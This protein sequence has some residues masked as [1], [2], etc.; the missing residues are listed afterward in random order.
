M[1]DRRTTPGTELGGMFPRDFTRDYVV[2]SKGRGPYVWDTE[3]NRYIDAVSGNKN[4]NIGHGRPEI[5]EAAAEQLERLEFSGMRFANTPSIEFTAKIRELT[6]D[7]Y[8]HAWVV[9][10]G[11]LANESAVK[12]ARQYH[13]ERGNPQKYKI[14][15][16]SKSYHGNTTGAMAWSGSPVYTSSMDPLFVD[17]PK[18][19]SGSQYRCKF[20][21]GDGGR[22]CGI[23]CAEQVDRVIK[24]EGPEN[25]AAFITEPVS[26][27]INAGAYPHDGYFTRVKE[28][29]EKHDVLFIAD[30]V[31]TGFGRTGTVFAME[32]W[33]VMPD[34]VTAG[35]GITAGY[36]PI[37]VTIPHEQVADVFKSLPHGFSHG[38]TYTFSPTT[39]AIG[40]AVL[41]YIEDHDLIDN[42][43]KMGSYL[44][45]RLQSL[46]DFPWV[47]DVRGKGLLQGIEFV[48]DRESKDRLDPSGD[49]FQQAFRRHSLGN[50]LVLPANGAHV[51]GRES[52]HT[53]VAPP[54]TV[55]R[56]LVD[57]I[58]DRLQ[59][60]LVGIESELDL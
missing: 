29:C 22:E 7:P 32:H 11:S 25:V 19:P 18:V 30:E 45:E 53:L 51:E 58:V 37:G 54:L 47:G 15:S 12:M 34:I 40:L 41:E 16:R 57:E 24:S 9:S 46:Y 36:A 2:L 60:T 21:D 52:D 59:T 33:N 50:G 48:S 44:S 43:R 4:V 3:G 23:R 38:H 6:P 42:A 56:E 26:G 8:R 17:S 35:K 31:L 39:A 27:L 20:C 14:I 28:I 5:A 10:G 13:I 49:V 55:N 1:D